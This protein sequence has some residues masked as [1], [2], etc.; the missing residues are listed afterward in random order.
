MRGLLLRLVLDQQHM[1]ADTQSLLTSLNKILLPELVSSLRMCKD[2]CD[3]S[4]SSLLPTSSFESSSH[5]SESRAAYFARLNK[6]DGGGGWSPEM[7]DRSPWL[8]IDLQERMEVTAVA[9][10]GRHG[11]TD[12]VSAYMLLYSDTGRVWKQYLLE[13][14]VGR[15][16]GNVNAENVVHHKLSHPIRTRFLRWVPLEWSSS[17]RVGLRLAVY[18]CAYRSY[19]TD[20]DGRSSLLYRFSQKSMSTVKDVISLRFKSG[21]A[22]GVLLHGEGQRGDYI[23]LELHRGR[24][25][26]HL[27]LDGSKVRPSSTHL[28]VTL[29]SLLDD[30]HWHSVMIE[31]FNKQVNFTL[32]RHTQHFRTKGDGDSLEVDYELSFG[33]IPLPGKP[34]TFIRRNFQ[35][36]IENLYYNGVNIIDLAKRRKPQIYSVGNVT[37]TCAEP[38]L[39]AVTFQSSSSSFL[40]VPVPPSIPEGFSVRLQF[41]TWNPDGLLLCSPLT[42]TQVPSFLVLQISSGRLHLTHQTSAQK[43]SEVSTGQR[44]NDGLWH[45]VSVHTRGLQMT[46]T[47]DRCPASRNDSSCLN[48]SMAFQGCVRLILINNQPVDL[49]SVQQ[50]LLGKYSQLQFDIC[51]IRDRCLYNLCEH[52]SRCS[53]TWSSFSCDCTATGYS[54]AT[55]HNSIY[56]ASCEHYRLAGSTSGYFSIDPDGSGSLDPIQVYCNVTG[57]KV[58]TLVGHNASSAGNVRGSTLQKPYVGRLGYSGSVE[59]MKALLS[60]SEHCEQKIS[61]RCRRSRL[62][63]PWDGSPLSWWVDRRGEKRTYWDGFQPGVQQCSCGLQ[64]NCVDINFFCNCDAD[65]VSWENDTGVLSYKEHLPVQE[66]VIGDT[67]RLGSEAQY[68]V[69][70]LQCTGDRSLW[71]AVSFYQ[72]A[73]YLQFPSPQAELSLDV[74]FYFKTASFSGVFL[75]NM[76]VHD[77]IRLELSSSSVVTFSFNAGD[78]PVLLT[79]KSPVPLND[80]QWHWVRAERNVKEACLQID[81]LP[82]RVMESPPDGH[83]RLQLGNQL[84]VGGT[85]TR[86]KGFL[87]C[88]RALNVNGVSLDL[89]ERA[90]VTPGV[91]PGCAGHCS[92]S[93]GLCHNR[94]RCIEKSS[95]YMCDCSNS[96]YG[97]PSCTEEV[98]MSFERGASVT[99]IFQ[100][101]FSVIQNRSVAVLS[102]PSQYSQSRDS[103]ALGF[104][105]TQSPAMLLTVNTLSQQYVAIILA[106]NGSLQIWYKLLKEKRPDVFSP[107]P[108]N[109][110]DGRLHRVQIQRDGKDLFV[111][112]DHES[113]KYI[114]SYDSAFNSVKSLTL[115]KVTAGSDVMDEEVAQAGSRG[116]VGCFSSVQYNHV[117]PLKA[118]L[119]NRGSSL[120]SM[121]G[122]LLE[123]NCGALA[124]LSTSVSR[125]DP[126]EEVGKDNERDE[127]I[128]Q[129]DSA[130]ITGVVTAAIFSTLCV[131]AVMLRF[132]Y[133]HRQAQRTARLQEKEHQRSLEAAY[134]AEFHLHKSIR[135]SM[136]EY[137]I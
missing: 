90:K 46:M 4:L 12:W 134:R 70:P 55:C 25:A 60:R 42:S 1:S 45:S 3:G 7:T 94:G 19:V 103:M 100:E 61:I 106:R 13:D 108:N 91:S 96:A 18:G 111:Q 105:T 128:R 38:K 135:D 23:T 43:M 29:G 117:A 84:S 73:S 16:V 107:A 83:L 133:Q 79:V 77:F 10:Q 74:S 129:P 22:E 82:L 6:R 109:L 88:I 66:V 8:Q 57:H 47:L 69:G 15:I 124:D 118:A 33:G 54:G 71:N 56:E 137:Y 5:F 104:Q 9:T 37:F 14:S 24:L 64:E 112:V 50:G 85:A 35:G 39:V 81:Q 51:S 136:Q 44:V 49:L 62:F 125:L 121:R 87:G 63:N 32:D 113:R 115:G 52:G 27:N 30:L 72:A 31:R 34:G 76:G 53:Q 89:E 68:M 131:L 67:H 28:L 80:R 48:P 58:W 102:A 116:F 2:S 120:V 119:L 92:S 21:Q 95:G 97:G 11:S 20:F 127:D 123:S 132:L 114:L 65:R 98:S 78:G 122:N 130:L 126:G 86:Q 110:A 26:L 36:C 59:Q 17:G 40:S 93:T 99:Y 75:E 101:P 41:R